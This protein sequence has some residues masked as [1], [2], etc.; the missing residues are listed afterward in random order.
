MSIAII[1]GASSGLGRL[2]VRQADKEGVYDQIWAIARRR[3]RLDELAGQC[4]TE[5]RCIC[6]DLSR[7]GAIE[8]L[9]DMLQVQNPQVSLLV[10]AAGFGKFGTCDDLSNEEVGAMIDVNCRAL[11]QVTQSALPYM[12]RGSRIVQ[13]ASCAG[14]QPLPGLSVYAASKS[15]VLSYTRSLRYELRGR[16]IRITAVCPIWVRTEFIKVARETANGATVRHPWPQI[17]PKRVVAWSTFVNRLNYPVATCSIVSLVMRLFCKVVPAPLIMW[18][19][20]GVRR[21]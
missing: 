15:F 20:E 9:D 14:F 16:G 17:S 6:L 2:Y 19:W 21:V 4:A 8:Q 18:I 1:T 12:R 5:V 7:E 3:E 11:V 13:V 10:N